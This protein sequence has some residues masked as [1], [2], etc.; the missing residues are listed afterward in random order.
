MQVVV[1]LVE[2]ENPGNIGAIARVMKNFDCHELW[3]INP[4]TP[5]DEEARRRA[6]HAGDILDS[7]TLFTSLKD[8]VDKVDLIVAT[9][10]RLGRDYNVRRTALTP[11]QLAE[12]LSTDKGTVGLVFGRESSGLSN[13]E[14]ELANI[15]VSIP[16]SHKYASLNLS[17][18]IAVVLYE[19]SAT[20]KPS[21]L[22]REL[23]TQREKELLQE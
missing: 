1:I 13:Q 11:R 7:A 2:P 12:S 6:V 8:A 3:M 4:Q 22:I 15:V 5:I 16:T 14:L 20:N 21:K 9:T 10:A 18:A 17:H 19:L 23:S